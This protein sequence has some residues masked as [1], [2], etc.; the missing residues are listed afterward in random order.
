MF[1]GAPKLE[2]KMREDH[3]SLLF[4]GESPSFR[5]TPPVFFEDL[6]LEGIFR[7]IVSK[8]MEFDVSLFFL[9]LMFL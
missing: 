2:E 9:N 4:P 1:L 6:Q 3:F 5:S 8:Y 7:A